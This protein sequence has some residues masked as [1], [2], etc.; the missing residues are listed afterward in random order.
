MTERAILVGVITSRYDKRKVD[1]Y[2]DELAFLVDTAGGV[3]A[4]RF[5]QALEYPDPRTFV[6]T[7][8]LQEIGAFIKEEQIDLV[9][10][11]DEL[12][13]SQLRNIERELKCRILDR[14]NLILDIFAKRAHT[15][16]A[17]VQVE[18]AQYEYM[19]PRLTRLW[20][21]LERQR[22]GI[23]MRGPGEREIETDRRVIRQK[24]TLLKEKL[25]EIDKQ[26][27]IQRKH[28]EQMVRVALV[29]Y[30]N[31]GKS[32]LMNQLA[33]AEV[34][35]EDKLFATLDT[36]VR[37]VVIDNLPFLIADT[38]GF[39]RKLPH[40][41][42]ESF[43]STLD[44]TREADILLHIIDISHPGFEEQIAIV[45]QTLQ[46]IGAA[47][48]RMIYLFNKIDAYRFEAPDPDD[49]FPEKEP[50]PTL[51]QL[52]QSWMGN[53]DHPAVFISAKYKTHFDDLKRILYEEVK[54]IHV[55]RFPY[56]HFLF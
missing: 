21:H 50:M 17:R 10:F 15:A 8:K 39:I 56:D 32:T 25:N 37:K 18:L 34:F 1:E 38:V 28:R 55:K 27:Y 30:T 4:G 3:V 22:G 2:L 12:S 33:K 52:R 29:G 44:E 54:A 31:V 6:G 13:P 51:G 24:I 49:L 23:G 48:K 5:I 14:N 36:T 46:E 47:D 45:N 11:D 41:L 7:G 9:V 20:T 42:V 16:H 26:K 40:T 43:K 19:L 53:Q 35:A